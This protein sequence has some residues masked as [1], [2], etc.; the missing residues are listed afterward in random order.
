M[1]TT[2]EGVDVSGYQCYELNADDPVYANFNKTNIHLAISAML[3]GLKPPTRIGLKRLRKRALEK[4]FGKDRKTFGRFAD[5][6]L[7]PIKPR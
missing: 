5:R 6:Q 2:V 4:K 7:R 3:K 1:L